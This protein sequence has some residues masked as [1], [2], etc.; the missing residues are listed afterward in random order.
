LE[1]DGGLIDVAG[2]LVPEEEG[3]VVGDVEGA[4]DEAGMPPSGGAIALGSLVGVG[5][6]SPPDAEPPDSPATSTRKGSS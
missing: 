6:P 3:A 5:E 1:F 2:A 4:V